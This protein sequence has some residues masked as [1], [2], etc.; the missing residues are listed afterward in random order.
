MN[1]TQRLPFN[2]YCKHTCVQTKE[3][4]ATLFVAQHTTIPV[5]KI[6]LRT[7]KPPSDLCVTGFPDGPCWQYSL[8]TRKPIGPFP[9]INAFHDF[10]LDP[11]RA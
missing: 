2:L 8:A 4:L 1:F 11:D 6:L 3:V 9:S 7:L 10:I 5:P